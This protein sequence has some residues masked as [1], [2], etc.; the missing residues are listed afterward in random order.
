VD[1]DAVAPQGRRAWH[2]SAPLERT[3]FAAA[4]ALASAGTN[5]AHGGSRAHSDISACRSAATPA[6]GCRSAASQREALAARRPRRPSA[7]RAE[8][9]TPYP[10]SPFY[11]AR[12]RYRTYSRRNTQKSLCESRMPGAAENYLATASREAGKRSGGRRRG[13]RLDMA[14]AR[15]DHSPARRSG[16]L[17]C[18]S[19]IRAV[20]AQTATQHT[21]RGFMAPIVALWLEQ[22]CA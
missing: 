19:A 12:A 11:Q 21:P 8:D 2:P 6:G 4:H 14:V 10:T 3:A 9:V 7:P 18:A 5:K 15:A 20:L 1:A 22:G 16:H 13:E 17:R